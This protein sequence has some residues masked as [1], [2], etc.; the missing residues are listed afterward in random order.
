MFERMERWI[1][2]EFCR[3]MQTRGERQTN[4]SIEGIEFARAAVVEGKSGSQAASQ[5][6]GGKEMMA[7]VTP[8]WNMVWIVITG[9]SVIAANVATVFIATRKKEKVEVEFAKEFTSSRDF[10][11]HVEENKRAHEQFDIRIGGVDRKGKQHADEKL[12]AA[13]IK[14][15]ESSRRMHSDITGLQVK[16]GQLETETKNQTAQ[17]KR[18]DEK[19]DTIT[20]R[21]PRIS[22]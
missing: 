17:L 4:E 9:L 18:M 11:K 12:A 20:L 14:R 16:V 6:N 2:G 22:T 1:V 8:N 19:L 7:D 10:W 3:V 21:L 15:E 13:E 5:N